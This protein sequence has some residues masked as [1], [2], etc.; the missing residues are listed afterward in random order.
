MTELTDLRAELL[1]KKKPVVDAA[2]LDWNIDA[3]IAAAQ[4]VAEP[5]PVA[6][7]DSKPR[8]TVS[9]LEAMRAAQK[10]FGTPE[11]Q[12]RGYTARQID[13]FLASRWNLE[14][15]PG[16]ESKPQSIEQIA[17]THTHRACSCEV[18]G[19]LLNAGYRA[20]TDES[21]Q[22]VTWQK[23]AAPKVEAPKVELP[24][25]PPESMLSEHLKA[26]PPWCQEGV[27]CP[28]HCADKAEA[29]RKD[30]YWHP[31]NRRWQR[32]GGKL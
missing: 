3:A 7:A 26:G 2:S 14:W 1:A 13:E 11:L 23:I 15:T 20:I 10:N 28:Q 25:F 19:A 4:P 9:E 21:G 17:K 8:L 31:E 16:E 24:E 5:V 6:P 32:L 30:F 29:L 12:K 22:R 27:F 18:C